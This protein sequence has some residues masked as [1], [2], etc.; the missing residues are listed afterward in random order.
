MNRLMKLIKKIIMEDRHI[1][2]SSLMSKRTVPTV[3]DNVAVSGFCLRSMESHATR[4]AMSE[5]ETSSG[6]EVQQRLKV[7][8]SCGFT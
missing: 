3:S 5:A 6:K 7:A 8:Q 2:S 1:F 4:F